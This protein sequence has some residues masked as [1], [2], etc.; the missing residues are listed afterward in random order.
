MRVAAVDYGKVR[1]GL[2][3][4]DELGSMAHPRPFLDATNIKALLSKL[5]EF[6]QQETVQRFQ[7]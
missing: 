1:A 3:L 6:A 7:S 2:A 4:S 5:N